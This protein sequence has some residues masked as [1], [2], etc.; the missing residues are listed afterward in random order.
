MTRH[1]TLTLACPYCGVE[2]DISHPGD[3]KPRYRDCPRCGK[4]FIY[5]PLAQGVDC[6]RPQDADCCSD[7]ECR[8][9]EMGGSDEE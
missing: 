1:D 2:E 9:T 7:P 5:E 8:A 3:Y 4:R 6:I